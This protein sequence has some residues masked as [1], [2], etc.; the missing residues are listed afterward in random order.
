MLRS[1]V[2][3]VPEGIEAS[4]VCDR[5]GDIFEM[6]AEALELGESFVIRSGYVRKTETNEKLLERVRKAPVVG[7][8][9]LEIPRDSHGNRKARKAQM[10]VSSC[11]VSISKKKNSLSVNVV[12]IAEVTSAKG[13]QSSG[14]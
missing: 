8:A 1:S 2:E 3:L 13:F 7:W 12:R 11:K 5:E 10:A 4:T 6:Y 14:F 9:T